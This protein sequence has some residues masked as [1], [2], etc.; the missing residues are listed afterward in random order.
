MKEVYAFLKEA[1]TYYLA[2]MDGD[3]PRV[4]PFGTVDIFEDKLYIQTGIS[5]DVAKQMLNNPKVE[6]S[7]MLGGRWI[8]VSAVAVPDENIAAQE[9]MLESYPDLRAMYQPGDGNTA[10]F[11]L[12]NATAVIYS[13]TEAPKV[14]TF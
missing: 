6:I 4:R 7:A 10:V 12:K 8:R 2:T 11:Y 14:I 1:G 9:H 5:K 3:Q 13:F